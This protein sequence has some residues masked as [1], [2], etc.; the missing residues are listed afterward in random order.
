MERMSLETLDTSAIRAPQPTETNP[1]D[2]VPDETR[3]T[4]R[5]VRRY[6][7]RRARQLQRGVPDARDAQDR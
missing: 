5:M 2:F 3:S 7:R 6:R 4:R 1:L